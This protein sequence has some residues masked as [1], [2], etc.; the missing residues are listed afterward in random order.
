MA[1]KR[2]HPDPR[3]RNK[4]ISLDDFSRQTRTYTLY[5]EA[6][7]GPKMGP[8]A[9]PEPL[10]PVRLAA[11]VE[12]LRDTI[13]ACFPGAESANIYVHYPWPRGTPYPGASIPIF[14]VNRDEPQLRVSEP[15]PTV[16]KGG[17]QRPAKRASGT[18]KAAGGNGK[19]REPGKPPAAAG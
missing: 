12:W 16:A 18:T 2:Q 3:K 1:T 17:R 5:V 15:V 11:C 7:G 13:R 9:P 19:A 6:M 4:F 10:D 14:H 8:L